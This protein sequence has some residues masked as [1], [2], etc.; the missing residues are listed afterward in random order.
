VRAA[1]I[2]AGKQ[3]VKASAASEEKQGRL[4]TF[5]VAHLELEAPHAGM[6]KSASMPSLANA[7]RPQTAAPSKPAASPQVRVRFT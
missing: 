1:A 3:V 4:F 7:G 2:A 5:L 6:N